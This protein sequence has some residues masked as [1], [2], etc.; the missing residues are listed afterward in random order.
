MCL[1]M[2]VTGTLGDVS[3]D[4]CEICEP[5]YIRVGLGGADWIAVRREGRHSIRGRGQDSV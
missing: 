1:S 2:T 3:S 5:R 4:H